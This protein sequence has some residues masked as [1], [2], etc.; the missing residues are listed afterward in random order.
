MN[1]DDFQKLINKVP[2]DESEEA[3]DQQLK[4]EGAAA[5]K[6]I[7]N[8]TSKTRKEK[9]VV[10][11]D[12]KSEEKPDTLAKKEKQRWRKIGNVEKY[13]TNNNEHVKFE[14]L[15]VFFDIM[16]GN[17]IP[18]NRT[19]FK[20]F[21][22]GNDEYTYIGHI[23]IRRGTLI[24]KPNDE[25]GIKWH[26][27][28]VI[29]KFVNRANGSIVKYS[30]NKYLPIFARRVIVKLVNNRYKYVHP[31][32]R[33]VKHNMFA[34]SHFLQVMRNNKQIFELGKDLS[35]ED[36][37]ISTIKRNGVDGCLQILIEHN[38][39]RKVTEEERLEHNFRAKEI[40]QLMKITKYEN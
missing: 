34:V 5:L 32:K 15:D 7:N 14:A 10:T 1:T 12:E 27:A 17:S 18:N 39:I 3:C 29:N 23:Y 19:T 21:R 6:A 38:T 31:N 37:D 8:F 2:T 11:E 36:A 35:D 9:S 4:M 25:F 40:Y 24:F 26:E 30:S 22:W 20:V 33:L 13:K 16:E 28:E